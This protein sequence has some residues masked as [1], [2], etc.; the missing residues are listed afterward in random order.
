MTPAEP[1]LEVNSLRV[2]YGHRDGAVTAVDGVTFAL[3]AG[4]RLAIVGESGSGKSTLALALLRLIAPPGRIIA[5]AIRLGGVDLLALDGEAM[6]QT[7]LAR[8]ALIPQG[9]MNSLNP[10]LRV[11]PQIADALL[12]HEASAPAAIEARVAGLLHSVGLAPETARRFPHELSGGMKQRVAIAIAISNGPRVI[13]ADEPTSALDVVVQRQVMDTLLTLQRE[14]RAAIVLVGHDIGLVAQVADR[15]G[16]MYA[17]RLVELGPI[18]TMLASPGHPYSRA[19]I[20]SVPPLSR[21]LARLVGI[22]GTQPALASLPAGCA[23]RPRCP[24]AT[25]RCAE[26]RP[27]LSALAPHHVVACHNTGKP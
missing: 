13:V 8:I 7:R 27:A 10:V 25:P 3:Q 20:A 16:V 22:P 2:A 1:V 12:D 18:A 6:R 11:G 24:A 21:R 23:F 14:I 17:G 15:V 9:A 19:L 26:E 5:G 4:E